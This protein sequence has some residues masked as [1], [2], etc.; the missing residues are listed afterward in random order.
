MVFE[1]Y[2]SI[3]VIISSIGILLA[4]L[5]GFIVFMRTKR[6]MKTGTYVQLTQSKLTNSDVSILKATNNLKIVNSSISFEG[7]QHGV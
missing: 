3:L 1:N 2:M 7:T 5:L 4:V 6:K